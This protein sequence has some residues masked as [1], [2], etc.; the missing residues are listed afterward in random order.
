MTDKT[1]GTAEQPMPRNAP[2][3]K[4]IIPHRKYGIVVMERISIPHFMT[5]ASDVYINK[6]YGPAR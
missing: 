5:S 2:G 4:S 3:N 1:I 6:I